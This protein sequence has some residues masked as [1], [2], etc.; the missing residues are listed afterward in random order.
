MKN[1][2]DTQ[3]EVLRLRLQV[4]RQLLGSQGLAAPNDNDYPRSVTMSLLSGRSSVTTWAVMEL[5]P[6]LVMHFVGQAGQR[7][8]SGS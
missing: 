5:L 2:F 4:Q 7:L 8:R 3:R 6:L 1:S